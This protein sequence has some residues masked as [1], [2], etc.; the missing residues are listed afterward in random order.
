[1]PTN[2]KLLLVVGGPTAAGK[3]TLAIALAQHFSTV[4]LSADSRQFY[5]EMEIGNARP[6]VEE[7]AAVPHFFVAN[8]SVEEPLSAGAFAREALS[9]LE[10]QFQEKDVVVLVGGSGLFVRAITEGL[11]EF[12][13]V[14][15]ATRAQVDQLYTE[16][17]LAGLQSILES[18][19]P[20][21]YST[22]DQQNP[23]RL[24]RA[25]EVYYESGKP[26]SSFRTDEPAE[27]PFKS[28]Y[29]QPNW[30]RE[31]L[32]ARINKR[33]ELMVSGGLEKEA[34]GLREYQHL[35]AL[36]T[37]GYQEWWPYF[38]GDQSL[39]RTVELIQQNTRNYAKRQLTWNRRDGYWKLVP[40]ADIR[41]ALT[42]IHLVRDKENEL[43]SFPPCDT[44]MLHNRETRKRV[45][46]AQSGSDEVAAVADIAIWKEWAV[47]R[48]W[49]N[50]DCNQAAAAT[51]LHEACYRT[52]MEEV[53]TVAQT[54]EEV[55]L[56]SSL[57]WKQVDIA[58]PEW[59][60]ILSNKLAIEQLWVWY[61]STQEF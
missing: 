59:P 58:K 24:R 41:S 60:A 40:Q 42:Y 46:L 16:K 33:V 32:Y 38:D 54:T 57:G 8:R 3:T 47:L 5:R 18:V 11:D 49:K 19:D 7:L 31:V 52:E 21:Y 27:R 39:E 36:Q 14:S 45:A 2:K 29:L 30:P 51:I 22:V 13:E 37:V 23:A 56:L 48:T 55:Q 4:I 53:Y 25:L 15:A 10:E 28:I 26:Y 12:P 6:S 43:R 34:Q 50:A 44:I 1:M 17:G 9:L 20:T 61:R 35:A